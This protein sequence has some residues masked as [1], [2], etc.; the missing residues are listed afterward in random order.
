[1]TEIQVKRPPLKP[2][3]GDAEVY[4]GDF[5][6]F[7]FETLEWLSLVSLESPRVNSN[8]S[9]DSFLSRY[10]PA[11]GSSAVESLAKVTWEG[12]LTP[13]WAHKTFVQALRYAPRGAWFS[14][15]IGGFSEEWSGDG[16]NC[17]I[18]KVPDA[19]NE[20]VLWDVL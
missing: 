9:V 5:E 14:F 3:V 19:P 17:T 18:L 10:R 4:A 7:A 12:F 20:Y 6:D 13:S 2:L 16:H 8:D 1:M 15:Y 11:A